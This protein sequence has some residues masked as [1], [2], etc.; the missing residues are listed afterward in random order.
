MCLLSWFQFYLFNQNNSLIFV[1]CRTTK[2]F[3]GPAQICLLSVLCLTEKL[4]VSQTLH[5]KWQFSILLHNLF[6]V[7]YMFTFFY[8]NISNKTLNNYFNIF[9]LCF[10]KSNMTSFYTLQLWEIIH[11]WLAMPNELPKHFWLGIFFNYLCHHLK[12]FLTKSI[13]NLNQGKN[14]N[15]CI[16]A[17]TYSGQTEND[18]I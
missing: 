2:C 4:K 9:I 15:C 17:K 11:K 1:K 12:W 5:N 13:W 3:E 7:T 6:V 16:K 14:Q 10:F 18:T 8:I